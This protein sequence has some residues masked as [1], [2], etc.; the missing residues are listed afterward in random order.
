MIMYK[1]VRLHVYR[2]D[3]RHACWSSKY[4]YVTWIHGY[5]LEYA[6]YNDAYRAQVRRGSKRFSIS[7]YLPQTLKDIKIFTEY[8]EFQSKQLNLFAYENYS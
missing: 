7:C 8:W 4:Y 2:Q 5:R 3:L 6:F 1:Q